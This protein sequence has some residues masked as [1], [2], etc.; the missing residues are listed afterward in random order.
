FRRICAEKIVSDAYDAATLEAHDLAPS[1][2]KF[3]RLRLLEHPVDA[4]SAGRVEDAPAAEPERDVIRRAVALAVGDDVAGL[5]IGCHVEPRL[6]LLV[7]VARD[8]PAGRPVAHVHKPGAID[9]SRR[10]PTPLVRRPEI[11][12][13]MLDR[14][15]R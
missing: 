5:R 13:C 15:V 10:L 12:P 4:L 3:L 8:E 9:P 1:R 2:T 7:G 6:L 14:F 11:R